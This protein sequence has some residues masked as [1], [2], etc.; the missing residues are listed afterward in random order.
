M[1]CEARAVPPPE[2]RAASGRKP[3]H[4]PA[5]SAIWPNGCNR[6]ARSA[7]VCLKSP[8][9]LGSESSIGF[10]MVSAKRVRLG[11]TNSI[12]PLS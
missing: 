7:S 5:V 1:N 8:S 10:E 3:N 11:A 2:R 6:W 12:G 9:S 4:P